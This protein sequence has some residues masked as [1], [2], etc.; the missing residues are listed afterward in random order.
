MNKGKPCLLTSGPQGVNKCSISPKLQE[1][2]KW[3]FSVETR[4]WV[5]LEIL[6]PQQL[7]PCKSQPWAYLATTHKLCLLMDIPNTAFLEETVIAFWLLQCVILTQQECPTKKSLYTSSHPS[8][9]IR[10]AGRTSSFIS[11]GKYLHNAIHQFLKI[12]NPLAVRIAHSVLPFQ[13]HMLVP[14]LCYHCCV[15]DPVKQA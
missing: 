3:R 15:S 10:C 2:L 4:D 11:A 8:D 12:S 7:S 6:N 9:F 14:Q 1:G 13:R 5:C